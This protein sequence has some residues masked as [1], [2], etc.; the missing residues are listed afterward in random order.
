MVA[1][2]AIS[3]R[4][5]KLRDEQLQYQV[6]E[7]I[8]GF[9]KMWKLVI[10]CHRKQLQG[11]EQATH[12]ASVKIRETS[13]F[14]A[15]GKLRE[16]ILNWA[17]CFEHYIQTQ[18]AFVKLLNEWLQRCINHEP[19]EDGDGNVPV[20][21][22]RI[23]APA[24]FIV[25]NDWCNAI[26][27]ICEDGVHQAILGFA[28][29]LDELQQKRKEEQR[30]R[31]KTLGLLKE[32]EKQVRNASEMYTPGEVSLL[33]ELEGKR[34]ELNQQKAAH[35]AAFKLVNDA[36]SR[37]LTTGLSP[38]FEVLESFCLEN[39]EAYEKIRLT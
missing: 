33:D 34:E 15:T 26:A 12:V 10:E 8:E 27:D 24:I 2:D 14:K 9:S 20:S 13:G 18:K 21:P 31:R 17:A 4:I 6:N 32:F 30:Q 22:S 25:C 19:E 11:V 7:L 1:I 23:G 29:C 35:E 28:S 37:C 39:V 5:H 36:A 16:K 38:I 3:A